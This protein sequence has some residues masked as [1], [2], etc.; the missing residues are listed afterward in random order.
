[1]FLFYSCETTN[2]PSENPLRYSFEI[3]YFK[4]EPT[5]HYREIVNRIDYGNIHFHNSSSDSTYIRATF[6]NRRKFRDAGN[7]YFGNERVDIVKAD[8]LFN[9]NQLIE[10]FID[11]GYAY[12]T[13]LDEMKFGEKMLISAT[14]NEF[15]PYINSI[16]LLDTSLAIVNIDS[17]AVISKSKGFQLR[18]NDIGFYNSRIRIYNSENEFLIYTS[19]N[20]QLEITSEELKKI[21]LGDYK[22]ECLKGHYLLDSASNNENVIINIYSAYIFD[23]SIK[24]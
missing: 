14:G 11:Y 17:L 7:L 8:K 10:D 4:I 18:T 3:P 20:E 6:Y 21:P 15:P 2:S 19:F 24:N 16:N 9:I 1:M 13:E 5:I 23:T 22:I 12:F